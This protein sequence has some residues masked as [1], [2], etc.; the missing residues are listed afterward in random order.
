MGKNA[1]TDL[2]SLSKFYEH[3]VGIIIRFF[4]LQNNCRVEC[5]FSNFR[6]MSVN[7]SDAEQ[8]ADSPLLNIVLFMQIFFSFLTLLFIVMN[9]PLPCIKR[10]AIVVHRNLKV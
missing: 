8:Y 5:H 7:C 10:S 6:L 9:L 3:I 4:K 2:L 1:V